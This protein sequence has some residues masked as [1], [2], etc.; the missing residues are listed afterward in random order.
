MCDDRI[1]QCLFKLQN[2]LLT[3]VYE[4]HPDIMQMKW[5]LRKLCRWPGM[6]KKIEHYVKNC[7]PCK[8]KNC[9]PC[10]HSD[11][12]H[13][14]VK[15][16]PQPIPVPEKKWTK[17]ARDVTGLFT[18]VLQYQQF[19]LVLINYT[20]LFLEMLLTGDITS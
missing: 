17:L 1:V 19:I 16:L 11:K 12:S 14:T 10:I 2:R 6:D 7:V 15:A 18:N 20:M 5:Q 13:Y 8:V 3:M 4:D 9:V